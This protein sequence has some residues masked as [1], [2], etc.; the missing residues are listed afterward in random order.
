MTNDTSFQRGPISPE[1]KSLLFCLV[2]KLQART[3]STGG[4]LFNLSSKIRVTP[5]QRPIYAARSSAQHTTGHASI[6]SPRG[7]AS[8]IDQLLRGWPTPCARDH[9]D[10]AEAN[11]SKFTT[12]P[13][14]VW[15]YVAKKIPRP[16]GQRR[17]TASGKILTGSEAATGSGDR[18]NPAHARWLMGLPSVW[19]DCTPTAMR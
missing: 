12:L 8:I 3:A 6:L 11:V 5:Q 13:R 18:S 10:G 19:D 7:I 2:S 4:T 14:V 16:G 9:R 15:F 17:R 1:S